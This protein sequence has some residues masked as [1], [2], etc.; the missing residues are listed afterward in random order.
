MVSSCW[1]VVNGFHPGSGQL[2]G[3]RRTPARPRLDR[4]DSLHRAAPR[5]QRS[6]TPVPAGADRRTQPTM[7]RRPGVL[8]VRCHPGG[9]EP[10]PASRKKFRPGRPT[11]EAFS[12]PSERPTGNPTPKPFLAAGAAAAGKDG[13]SLRPTRIDG[14]IAGPVSLSEKYSRPPDPVGNH[15]RFMTVEEPEAPRPDPDCG[16]RESRISVIPRGGRRRSPT[17]TTLTETESEAN[18]DRAGGDSCSW[19]S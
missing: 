8:P 2:P 9:R 3:S 17:R 14:T 16:R 12:R 1:V 4:P 13:K 18:H 5:D 19:C 6:A 7:R 10:P 11:P 15:Y